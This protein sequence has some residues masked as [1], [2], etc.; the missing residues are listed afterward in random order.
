MF[1]DYFSYWDDL[2]EDGGF[3]LFGAVHI[4]WL[5][6]ITG[7]VIAGCIFYKRK[8]KKSRGRILRRLAV[9][10]LVMS[11]YK[12]AVLTITGHMQLQYLPLQLCG[13]AVI[14]EI[15]YAFFPSVFLGELMCI[16]CLPGAAAAL[17]FPDWTRYPVI[18]YIS[19]HGFIMHGLLILIPCML[20]CAGDFLPKLRH[21]YIVIGFFA[22]I[23]PILMIINHYW[24]TNF[25]FLMRPSR[26]S[27]FLP[28]YE[29]YG[30]AGYLAVYGAVV[31]LMI[32]AMYGVAYIF[33]HKYTGHQGEGLEKS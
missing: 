28:A 18:N 31:L 32:L 22:V 3:T 26:G 11:V 9:L 24:D 15:I 5:L 2:P 19:L 17:I 12:D 4:I 29:R 6:L 1:D 13:M 30:Y 7:T 25:M 23:V 21:I 27:P 33:T 16:A 10:M 8:T 14:I 20:M